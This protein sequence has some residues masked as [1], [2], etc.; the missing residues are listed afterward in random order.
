MVSG[1]PRRAVILT[2][3]GVEY[4]AV[5]AHLVDLVEDSHPAG[6]L[7]ERGHFIQ[8]DQPWEVLIAEVGAHNDAAAFEAERAIQHFNPEVALFVGVAGGLKDVSV[9]DVVA[10]TRLYGYESGKD[11]QDFL[12]RPDVGESSF[13]LVQRARAEA[14]REAWL[15]RLSSPFQRQPKAFVGPIA[16]GSKVVADTRS[17]TLQ[18]IR[19]SYGDALAVEMEGRGFLKATHA[20]EHVKALVIRGISDLIDGK[21]EADA[22]GSQALAARHAAAFAFEV[23]AR[24]PRL[25]SKPATPS[26]MA[27]LL[28]AVL[29]AGGIR[30]MGELVHGAREALLGLP[31]G[32]VTYGEWGLWKQG[33][34]AVL[35]LLLHGLFNVWDGGAPERW[36]VVA[37]GAMVAG[38]LGGARSRSARV[39]ESALLASLGVLTVGIAFYFSAVSLHHVPVTGPSPGLCDLSPSWD[40]RLTTQVCLWLVNDSSESQLRRSALGGLWTWLF[41]AAVMG[42]VLSFAHRRKDRCTPWI[43]RSLTIAFCL[44]GVLHLRQAPQAWALAKWGVRYPRVTRLEASCKKPDHSSGIGAGTCQ[45]WD[46]SAGAREKV[47]LFSDKDCGEGNAR[48]GFVTVAEGSCEVQVSADEVVLGSR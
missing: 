2:A 18:L 23:L 8:E 15:K 11:G 17:A 46:V 42:A 3:L 24:H 6:T 13:M 30:W 22:S 10:A 44:L 33:M 41:A 36:A 4:A 37:T 14:R 32:Q 29:L 27:W 40:R 19:A 21:S 7:Y 35:G 31:E 45:A 16:A 12:P 26:G 5:R 1:E 47:L 34:S 39:T 48:P 28:L 43:S 20:N 25:A 9:G 38:T